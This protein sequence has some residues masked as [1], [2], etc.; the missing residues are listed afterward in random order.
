MT[1]WRRGIAAPSAF[2]IGIAPSVTASRI[3]AA[4]SELPPIVS[5]VFSRPRVPCCSLPW[6]LL[7]TSIT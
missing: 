7:W 3:S 4:R 1:F 5:T 6:M 2:S